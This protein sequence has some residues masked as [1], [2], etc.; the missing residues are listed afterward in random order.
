MPIHPVVTTLS[1]RA[2][3]RTATVVAAALC[4]IAGAT[5]AGAVTDPAAASAALAYEINRARWDPVAFAARS[6]VAPVDGLL[7]A[8]PMAWNGELTS[9]AAFK[10]TEIA[11]NDY[12][13][14][15][16]AVTGMWPNELARQH[17]YDIPKWWSGDA[18]YIESLYGGVS[19]P[20]R[21]LA[22]F[23]ASPSHRRHIF[24]EGG[25]S[26]Y[27]EIGVGMAFGRNAWWWAVHTAYRE[28]GSAPFVSGFV[29]D[30]LD[31]DG[32]LDA[33]EG[34]AGVSVTYDGTTVTTDAGGAYTMRA[35]RGRGRI[36]AEGG[37][38]GGKISGVIRVKRHNVWVDFVAGADSAVI[39]AYELCR[40]RAPTILGTDGDDVI[41]G[42]EG[43]DVIHGLDGDD[44]IYGL[45]G[46]DVVCGGR[47]DDW[48]EVGAGR[49][50]ALGER[51][52]DTLIGAGKGDRLNGGGG[53]DTL[54]GGRGSDRLNGGPGVDHLDA[55]PGTDV[56]IKGETQIGCSS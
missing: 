25:F 21:V 53:R 24:G 31:G 23:M 15:Q 18:N 27:D 3:L 56:C 13:G 40:G 16:S 49:D 46:D 26:G 17:G 12:F 45:G 9:S 43:P 7:A 4:V 8:P 1:I 19:D 44:V 48:I 35:R 11:G 52:V 51:G 41:H 54:H 29:F 14:H 22:A 47:G 37:A 36:V 50:L 10:A 30:D 39:R 34:L 42:T 28:D 6:G 55:G 5:A 33:G 38:L 20:V 2:R 32:Y